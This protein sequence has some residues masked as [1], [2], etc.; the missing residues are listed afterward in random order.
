M[1]GEERG[2][3]AAHVSAILAERDFTGAEIRTRLAEDFG[4]DVGIGDLYDVIGHLI[5]SGH[6][7]FDRDRAVWTTRR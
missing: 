1:N 2:N 5:R 4:I 7:R 6:I 3:F